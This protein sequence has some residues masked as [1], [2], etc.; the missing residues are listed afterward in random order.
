MGPATRPWSSLL[1][2]VLGVASAACGSTVAPSTSL[3][4]PPTT[5]GSQASSTS[6]TAFLTTSTTTFNPAVREVDVVLEPVSGDLEWSELLFVTYGEAPSEL[7]FGEAWGPE[8]PIGRSTDGRWWVADTYKNRIAILDDGGDLVGQ[9]D[10]RDLV[11]QGVLI[12]GDGSGMA[13]DHRGHP[14]LV[15]E[16]GVRR[17]EVSG[18]GFLV[19]VVGTTFYAAPSGRPDWRIAITVVGGE[20]EFEFVDYV[21]TRAGNR[22]AV[23]N[24]VGQYAILLDLPDSDTPIRLVLSMK[25]S[26]GGDALAGVEAVGAADGTIHLMLYG[27]ALDAQDRGLGLYLHIGSDGT[28]LRTKRIPDPYGERD[29]GTPAGRLGYDVVTD[30]PYIAVVEDDGLRIWR[31]DG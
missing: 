20:P 3:I 21:P 16:G 22:Y 8:L 1:V 6:T 2:M 13:V 5:T 11:L 15:S 9:I 28:I 26:S 19:D 27:Y 17:A 23:S 10:L 29:P 24:P 4:E 12:G 30:R 25:A 31:L 18:L 7:G 14:V